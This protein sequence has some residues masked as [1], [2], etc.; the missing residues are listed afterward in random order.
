[1]RHAQISKKTHVSLH[2]PPDITC[3]EVFVVHGIELA[4]LAVVWGKFNTLIDYLVRL[5]EPAAGELQ[6]KI[7]TN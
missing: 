3:S 1:M 5:G 7:S 4:A 2:P 6:Q